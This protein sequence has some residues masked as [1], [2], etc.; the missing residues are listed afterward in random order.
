MVARVV[1]Q[2]LGDHQ[3][4]LAK[5]RDLG[6]VE[7][8]TNLLSWEPGMST[9]AAAGVRS[10]IVALYHLCK[11]SRDSQRVFRKVVPP[12]LGKNPCCLLSKPTAVDH[13]LR[14]DD[15]KRFH[16]SSSVCMRRCP[17]SAASRPQSL[18]A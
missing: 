15:G 1:S 5:A 8:L 4:A 18:R 14:L 3:P 16:G 13:V 10:A 7:M 12:Y 2:I 6:A 11:T 9:T 17:D